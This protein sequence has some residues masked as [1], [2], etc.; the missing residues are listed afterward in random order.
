MET[1]SP[2]QNLFG[3]SPFKALQQHMR[4]VS[5]CTDQLP[6]LVAALVAGQG[7]QAN[8]ISLRMHDQE[9]EAEAMKNDLFLH[10]PKSLFM[11]VDRRDLLA[12]L[13]LNDE[14]ADQCLRVA[15]QIM[16]PGPVVPAPIHEGL[17]TASK[18]CSAVVAS[19][20]SIME[21]MDELVETGFGGREAK[22]VLGLLEEL[23]ASKKE[24]EQ[25]LQEVSNALFDE[26]SAIP[27][28]SV[29]FWSRL[30]DELA[31]MPAAAAKAGDRVRLLLAR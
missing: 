10:L 15:N 1:S 28:L 23:A 19:S 22:L 30:L 17:Q 29:V 2:F 13:N 26:K 20:R 31:K 25:A 4:K 12:I 9:K 21:N 24:A 16:A 7:E 8:T 5:E 11:P 27:P 14:V 18:K 6:A 3:K